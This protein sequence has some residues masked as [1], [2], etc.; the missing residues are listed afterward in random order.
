MFTR[1]ALTLAVLAL[2]GC[3]SVT[4][5]DGPHVAGTVQSVTV[6]DA[7]SILRLGVAGRAGGG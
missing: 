1:Y 7:V 6:Q 4:N 5:A 3:H 2:I